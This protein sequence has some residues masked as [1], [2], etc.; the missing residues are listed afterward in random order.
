MSINPFDEVEQHSLR[1]SFA[2]VPPGWRVACGWTDMRPRSPRERLA[3][4][5]FVTK[6]PGMGSDG[7]G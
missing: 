5:G 3:A 4:G 2:D 1:P 7:A 6:P